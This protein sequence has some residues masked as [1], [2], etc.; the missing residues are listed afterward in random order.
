MFNLSLGL[1]TS[2]ST[3]RSLSLEQCG[4]GDG[5]RAIAYMYSRLDLHQQ[6]TQMRRLKGHHVVE[7]A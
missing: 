4:L 2:T 3:L 7:P 6:K 5:R 1:D